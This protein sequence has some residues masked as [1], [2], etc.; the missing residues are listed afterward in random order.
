MHSSGPELPGAPERL[1]DLCPGILFSQRADFSFDY[2]DPRIEDWSGFSAREWLHQPD[3]LQ[4]IIHEPDAVVF[5]QHLAGSLAAT[6]PTQILFRIRN[7]QTG[8]IMHLAESRRAV[9][10]AAG[11]V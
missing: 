5:Q 6:T 11:T 1:L 8:R 7:R 4:Q 3:L 9:R 2:V 10:T